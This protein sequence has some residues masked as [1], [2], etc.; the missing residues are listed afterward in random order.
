MPVVGGELGQDLG[1]QTRVLG[2]GGRGEGDKGLLRLGAQRPEAEQN[3]QHQSGT[4]AGSHHSNRPSTKASASAL[5]GLLKKSSAGVCSTSRP[6]CRK[7]TSSARRRAWPRS[8]VVSTT[9][10][11]AVWK[12][13]RRSPRPRGSPPGPG[14]RSARRAAAPRARWPRPG[15]A[16]DAAARR[17]RAPAPGARARALRPTRSKASATRG[18]ANGAVPRRAASG[19]RRTLAA[20][21][22]RSSTGR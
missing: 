13:H 12:L 22:R 7:R 5:R 3:L 16:P 2:R 15:P 8:W 18:P 21:E 6:R 19:D 20:A 14:W 17:R 11:P 4:F 9:L 1:Q 10:V